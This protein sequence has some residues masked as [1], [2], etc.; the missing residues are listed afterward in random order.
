MTAKQILIEY[1]NYCK[2]Y[3]FDPAHENTINGFILWKSFGCEAL[4]EKVMSE[5]EVKAYHE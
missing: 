2:V 3:K 1:I 5:E 4:R